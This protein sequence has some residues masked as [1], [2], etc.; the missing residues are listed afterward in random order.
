VRHYDI[1]NLDNRDPQFIARLAD[2]VDRFVR[3]YFR[4]EVRG[5]GRIPPGAALYVG[6]HNGGLVNMEAYVFGAAVY[7][8]RGLDDVPFGLG[9]EIAISLPVLNQLVGPMGVVRASHDTAHRLFARGSKV[10]VYPGSDLD[11]MRPFRHRGRVVF[12]GRRGYVRLAL[13]EGVPVVPVVAAGAHSTLVILDDMRW[14]ARLVGADRFL[15]V[16]AWPIALALPWGVMFG[17]VLLYWPWPSRILVEVLDPIRF[18]RRGAEAA[19]D[20]AFVRDC[21]LRVEAAMQQALDALESERRGGVSQPR[22]APS[23]P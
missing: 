3:P 7:R 23:T 15:R 8:A 14:L 13:R 19:A 20:E 9:H 6:N 2:F 11:A 5:L 17:P 4:A 16:K 1:D 18:D 10:L 21:A 22:R 12:G